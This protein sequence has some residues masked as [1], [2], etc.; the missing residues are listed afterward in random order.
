MHNLTARAT[1]AAGNQATS[2]AL[3]V[4]IDTQAPVVSTPDLSSSSDSGSSNTDNVTNVTAPLFTGTAEAGA[5]V[6]L[7]EGATVLG[8][9]AAD[10]AGNWSISSSVLANGTHSIAARATDLAGNQSTGDTRTQGERAMYNRQR[11]GLAIPQ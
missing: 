8:I 11:D 6:Q 9:A 3:I 1:D 10:G 7:L 4:T 5:T 2:A